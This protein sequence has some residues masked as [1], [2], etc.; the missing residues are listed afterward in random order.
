VVD[1]PPRCGEAIRIAGR[2][3]ERRKVDCVCGGCNAGEC[4]PPAV[5]TYKAPF[6]PFRSPTTPDVYRE[7]D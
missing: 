5:S 1:I 4:T 3:S 2:R 6:V 7:I